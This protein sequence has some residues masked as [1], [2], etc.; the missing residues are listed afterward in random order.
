[1][2]LTLQIFVLN[3]T[4]FSSTQ[5]NSISSEYD[6]VNNLPISRAIVIN[7][8]R[9]VSQDI[10]GAKV[11]EL[12]CGTGFFTRHLLDWGATSVVGVDISQGMIDIAQ[13]EF[14]KS[15]DASRCQFMLADCTQPFDI[16]AGGFDLVF[17]AW[18]LNYSADEA[19]MT[20]IFR[21]ITRH[22]K[23]GGRLVTVAPHAEEDPMVSPMGAL[24]YLPKTT[25]R[26]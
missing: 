21:N 14:S 11:L 3:M 15:S 6:A 16:G 20:A 23:P 26:L 12:A 5:Y 13:A 22:L 18:L 17:A 25:I 19:I 2:R 24:N 4:H 9:A 7:V 1:M 8:E 10:K